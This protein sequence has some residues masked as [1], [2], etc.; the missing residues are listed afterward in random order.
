MVGARDY[1]ERA[2]AVY[3]QIQ[4]PAMR[5]LRVAG[6]TVAKH[7]PA[8][9]NRGYWEA[10][11]REHYVRDR[12]FDEDRSQVRARSWPRCSCPCSTSR[13]KKQNFAEIEHPDYPGERLACCRNP[14][15][16][17]SRKP[18]RE[19]LLTATEADLE[20]IRSVRKRRLRDKDKIGVRVGKV[21]G[22]HFT[23]EITDGGS[24][25]RNAG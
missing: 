3:D 23:R 15:L 16:A 10:E 20:K 12:T 24:Q 6:R 11:N 25:W 1:Y 7:S 13:T 21:I 2:V 4:A 8:N 5:S 19:A 17:E 14:A 18:K 9:S 22:K